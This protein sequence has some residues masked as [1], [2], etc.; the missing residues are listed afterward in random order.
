MTWARIA[1][2]VSALI[3]FV[4]LLCWPV[5]FAIQAPGRAW[6]VQRRELFAPEEATVQRVLVEH[7]Q[8]VKVGEP[9]LELTSLPLQ[10]ERT[11]LRGEL[12]AIE[13]R[14]R[15]LQAERLKLNPSTASDLQRAI[16]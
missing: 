7:G 1:V 4:A 5:T 15:S 9:L 11:E 6:P 10:Q 13:Q 12:A 3:F 8:T 16:N 14:L 2:L